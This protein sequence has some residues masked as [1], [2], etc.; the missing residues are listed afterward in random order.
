M[1]APNVPAYIWT[2][3]VS[4]SLFFGRIMNDNAVYTNLRLIQSQIWTIYD[5]FNFNIL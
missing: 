2:R 1:S 5:K 3:L 4:I